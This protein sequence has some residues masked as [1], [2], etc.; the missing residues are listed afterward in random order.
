MTSPAQFISQVRQEMA[1]VTWPSRKETT[2][3]TIMVLVLASVTAVFFLSVD[4]VVGSA[5]RFILGMGA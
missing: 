5:I 4:W 2:I 1:K 3:S